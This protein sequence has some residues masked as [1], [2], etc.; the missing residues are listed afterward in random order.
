MLPLG[1][2]GVGYAGEP[3]QGVDIM[4]THIAALSGAILRV[5][6]TLAVVPGERASAGAHGQLRAGFGV[7]RFGEGG[8]TTR[9]EGST[10]QPRGRSQAA[11]AGACVMVSG[12]RTGGTCPAS[13]CRV[14]PPGRGVTGML[15]VIVFLSPSSSP[16]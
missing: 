13:A 3:L 11:T 16:L 15:A 4:R 14:G 12:A 5:S 8:T 9:R 1:W 6:M 10:T 7:R 2:S